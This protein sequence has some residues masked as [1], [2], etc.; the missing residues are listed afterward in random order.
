MIAASARSSVPGFVRIESGIPIFPMSWKRAAVAS[1]P[2]CFAGR[3]SSRPIARETRRTRCEWPAVYGSRAS[4]AAFKCLDRLEER[5]LEL[6][7]G[8]EEIVRTLRQGLVLRLQSQRRAAGQSGERQPQYREDDEDRDPDRPLRVRDGVGHERVAERELHDS[9]RTLL[10][11]AQ[12]RP[13]ADERRCVTRRVDDLGARRPVP[14]HVLQVGTRA[15]PTDLCRARRREAE[16]SRSGVE[17][18]PLHVGPEAHRAT[19]EAPRL[20]RHDDPVSADDARR[21]RRVDVRP[22]V[23]G[24]VLERGSAQLG[25]QGR[26]EGDRADGEDDGRRG[27]EDAQE[28]QRTP[29]AGRAVGPHSPHASISARTRPTLSA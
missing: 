28:R 26:G 23:S 10:I 1:E 27:D 16:D 6:A 2:S 18:D 19:E 9:D 12:G 11:G 24:V 15:P 4:T 13:R 25:R 21:E 5:R 29:E 20:G 8:L 22:C 7:R 17:I 3:R 14:E